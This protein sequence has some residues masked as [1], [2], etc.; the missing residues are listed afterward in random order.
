MGERDEL[1]D[2]LSKA[3]SASKELEIEVVEEL[4]YELKQTK[5]LYDDES[6]RALLL[7]EELKESG[8]MRD[9]LEDQLRVVGESHREEVSLLKEEIEK[10]LESHAFSLKIS[11]EGF[12]EEIASL[13]EDIVSLRA[14][15]ESEREKNSMLDVERKEMEEMKVEEIEN[16]KEELNAREERM[17]TKEVYLKEVEVECS[18]KA[19]RVAAL[20]AEMNTLHDEKEAE[21]DALQGENNVMKKALEANEMKR[22][23]LREEVRAGHES[24]T[25]LEDEIVNLTSSQE[26]QAKEM[27]SLEEEANTVK[28]SLE[29][30][31]EKNSKLNE[32]VIRLEKEISTGIDE[33]R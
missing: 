2:D 27:A 6:K 3:M 21:V 33:R 23:E 14:S 12:A 20:E 8:S 22:E 5:S 1:K 7:G 25:R 10:N 24:I 11:E 17:N 4:E 29:M 13:K 15:L 31:V 18:V 32:E 19:E 16:L 28:D 26:K 9:S 30:E